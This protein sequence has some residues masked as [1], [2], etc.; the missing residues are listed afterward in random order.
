MM[1]CVNSVFVYC[2][3][4]EHIIVGD[5]KA[6]LL[7]IVDAEGKNGESVVKM[8][9]EPRYVPLQKKHFDLVEIDIRDQ[10]SKSLF[11]KSGRAFVMLHFKR[12]QSQYYL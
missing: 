11:F 7:R 4:L 2:D 8:F 6:P 5:T 1:R 9:E 10:F 3:G 12:A